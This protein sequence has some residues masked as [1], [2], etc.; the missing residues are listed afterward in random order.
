M[1]EYCSIV[2]K[3]L[4]LVFWIS[5]KCFI[6]SHYYEKFENL[7]RTI[8][9]HVMK[10]DPANRRSC[11]KEQKVLYRVCIFRKKIRNLQIWGESNW[12][13]CLKSRI[14]CGAKSRTVQYILHSALVT[15]HCSIVLTIHSLVLF[16]SKVQYYSAKVLCHYG[17]APWT[18]CFD[19]LILDP[20]SWSPCRSWAFRWGWCSRVGSG[21]NSG[22]KTLNPE[23]NWE[24]STT[25]VYTVVWRNSAVWCARVNTALWLANN[26]P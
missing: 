2:L 16:G 25:V 11:T 20:E 26:I 10:H 23:H 21:E 14:L 9:K 17:P 24:G 1:T 18:L 12:N 5:S 13:T 3:V 22:T 15:K 6:S 7:K 4:S 8:W 19:S